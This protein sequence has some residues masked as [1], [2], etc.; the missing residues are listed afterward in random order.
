MRCLGLPCGERQVSTAPAPCRRESLV[1]A[2]DTESPGTQGRLVE[3]K[4]LLDTGVGY[5]RCL[6]LGR[7][8][9]ER[10]L[11]P[12]MQTKITGWI[13]SQQCTVFGQQRFIVV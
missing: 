2:A 6:C 13:R 10:S 12:G 11:T 3:H 5:L 7:L 9:R 4:L 1:G 8:S